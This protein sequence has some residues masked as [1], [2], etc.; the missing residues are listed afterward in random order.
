MNQTKALIER[1]NAAKVDTTGLGYYGMSCA[2]QERNSIYVE[3]A[4]KLA[5]MLEIA[6]EELE[7]ARTQ[8]KYD[9]GTDGVLIGVHIASTLKEIEAIAG[10]GE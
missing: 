4:P 1:V 6:I 7:S 2:T 10:G 8:D 5:R 9:D 3:A